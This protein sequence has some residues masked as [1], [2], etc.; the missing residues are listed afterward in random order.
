MTVA[1]T[2]SRQRK[3][4]RDK[5]ERQLVRRADRQRRRRQIQAAIGAFLLV[6]L[7][8]VG[9]VWLTGGFE[10]EP[11]PQASDDCTWLPQE[12]D[13][14]R[15]GAGTP[16]G[17]PANAGAR[18]VTM[19]LDGGDTGS[20]EV[21]LSLPVAADPCAVASLEH[22]AGQG[23]YDGTTC[24]ELAN[25]A[26]RC[27]DPS[28]TGFGGPAY[29]FFAENVPEPP[30]GEDGEPPVVYPAG[31]VAFGDTFGSAGSQFLIFF[32]D[33]R[34]D[35]PLWSIIGEVTGGMDLLAAV[36]A[37]GT[38][39]D[40]TAPAEEVRIRSLTVTDPEAPDPGSIDES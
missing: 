31:T 27:G 28:G 18:T 25:G 3:L 2:R 33:Y 32:E 9:V 6:A 17:N 34:T 7:V 24:H 36:G 10:S 37:A 20:G 5:Y 4:A 12:G 38:A 30:P 8:V 26:L 29:S 15:V 13:P 23:F 14:N 35:D 39:E 40:S 22:L 19:A 21:E 1:P 16:P 11:E